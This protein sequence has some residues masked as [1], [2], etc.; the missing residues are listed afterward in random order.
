MWIGLLEEVGDML[1]VD[2]LVINQGDVMLLYTDGIT[3]ALDP[4][5]EMYSDE[6]LMQVFK[7]LGHLPPEE[8]KGG[9]INSLDG[10]NCTDDVTLLVLK[11]RGNA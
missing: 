5:E 7:E 8:I 10:Y 9:I 1:E 4:Q 2:K 11:R 3:E 6:K